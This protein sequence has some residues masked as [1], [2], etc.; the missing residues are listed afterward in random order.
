[1]QDWSNVAGITKSSK[2][3]VLGRNGGESVLKTCLQ[4]VA[5][6]PGWRG[7]GGAGDYADPATWLCA[8]RRK[9]SR[10]FHLTIT[11]GS[12]TQMHDHGETSF[13]RYHTRVT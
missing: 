6:A 13:A 5:L 12:T 3:E 7:E 10:D 4:Y 11:L 2:A 1:M 8:V 9:S